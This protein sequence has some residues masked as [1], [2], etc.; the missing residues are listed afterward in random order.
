MAVFRGF[1]AYRPKKEYQSLV[2]ALP[3]DVMSSLEAREEAEN[4]PFSF[5]HIDRAEIDFPLGVDQ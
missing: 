3:Y 1:R 4:K 5:L 2:P